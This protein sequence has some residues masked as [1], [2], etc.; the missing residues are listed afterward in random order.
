M[1]R[2]DIAH[3][4]ETAVAPVLPPSVRIRRSRKDGHSVNLELKGEPVRVTWLGE[5]GLRQARELIAGR[6]DRPDVAVARRMS[7]GARDA[8]SA[9]EIGWVDETGRYHAGR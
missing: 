5:G 6:E 9:A 8:L 3:R 4:S 1:P 7:P 2:V